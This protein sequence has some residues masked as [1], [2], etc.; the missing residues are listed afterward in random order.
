MF[1]G[2]LPIEPV[3]LDIVRKNLR[4]KGNYFVPRKV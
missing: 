4:Q 1:G 3:P 2:I